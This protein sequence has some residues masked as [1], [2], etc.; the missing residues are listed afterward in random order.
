M[1]CWWLDKIPL[2]LLLANEAGP[3]HACPCSMQ[4][5]FFL[6][7]SYWYWAIEKCQFWSSS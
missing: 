6:I 4:V 7:T 5:F 2:D 3:I 1:D